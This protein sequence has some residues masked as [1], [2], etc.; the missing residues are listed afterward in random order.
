MGMIEKKGDRLLFLDALSTSGDSAL[1]SRKIEKVA[2]TLLN[3]K[4]SL[5]PFY[6]E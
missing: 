2:C 4:S 3:R 1:S 6:R 5:S